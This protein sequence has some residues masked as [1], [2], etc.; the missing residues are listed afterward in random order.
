MTPEEPTHYEQ[1]NWKGKDTSAGSFCNTFQL[2]NDPKW[3]A[4]LVQYSRFSMQI[5]YF[6]LDINALL[7]NRLG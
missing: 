7:T 5:R 6:L 2:S 4:S 1:F 3:D